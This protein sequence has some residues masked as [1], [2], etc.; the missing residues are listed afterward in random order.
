V[1]GGADGDTVEFHPG[2]AEARDGGFLRTEEAFDGG[3]AE[4]DNNH[5]GNDGDLGSQVGQAGI[6]FGASGFT[7]SAGA[8]WHIGAALENISDIDLFAGEFHGGEHFDEEFTSKTDEGFA[9][10]VF[11]GARSFADKHETGLR[12]TYSEDDLGA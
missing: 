12:I 4:S 7:I 10:F 5:W 11:I 1:E 6:H 9:F 8:S 2:S 3:S